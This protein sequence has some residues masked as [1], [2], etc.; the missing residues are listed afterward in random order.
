MILVCPITQ[1]WIDAALV[2][3]NRA[4]A[5]T[6]RHGFID[7]ANNTHGFDSPALRGEA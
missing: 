3:G 6:H 1:I 2:A 4:S 5:A 7:K